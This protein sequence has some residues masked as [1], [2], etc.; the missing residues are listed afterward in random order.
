MKRPNRRMSAVVTLVALLASL[1]TFVVGSG[2]ADAAGCSLASTNGTVTKYV[3]FRTYELHVPAG[4]SGSSV[5]LLL[6]LHGGGGNGRIYESLTGWSTYADQQRDFIVAYPNSQMY[7]FWNYGE[8]SSE[9]TFL[10]N[11]V[12]S[13]ASKYC[14]DLRRV[15][16]DGHSNGGLMADRLACD[17]ASTFAAFAPY[18][19]SSAQAALQPTGMGGCNPS[20]PVP[21]AFF[22]GDQDTSAPIA[23][24]QANR[25]WWINRNGCATTPTTS[26]D[27]YGSLAVYS[28]C[29]GGADIW[30]RVVA[31]QT[32]AWPT[33][34][35]GEDQ[36]NRMWAFFDAHPLP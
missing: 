23:Y 16:V 2:S 32:H 8:G 33:G 18:A 9:V 24:Q 12:A 35:K 25:D 19:G 22:H 34:A 7:G 36:R 1:L 6:D 21:I 14:I 26:T 28:P 20:R 11:V 13:I 15:Y 5:P 27:T 17:A 4:L 10:R 29:A 31:N 30:W 3:G